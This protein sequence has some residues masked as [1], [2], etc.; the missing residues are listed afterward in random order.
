MIESLDNN[1]S[2]RVYIYINVWMAN[3]L[4]DIR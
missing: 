4:R 1:E 2:N 3:M